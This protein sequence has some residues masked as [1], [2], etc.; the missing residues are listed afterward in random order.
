MLTP[1]DDYPIHPS[2]DPIAHPATGDPNHYD[3]Y[4]FNGHQK[5]G[6]FYF[7]AAMGHYPVRGV[8]DAAFSIVLDG[9]EH[10]VFASGVMPVDRTTAVGPIRIEVSRAHPHHPLRGRAERTRDRV[11]PR[12]PGPDGRRRGAPAK[13]DL[14][15]GHPRDGPHPADPVGQLGGRGPR[16]RHRDQG[17][18]A[19]GPRERATGRGERGPWARRSR[20]IGRAACRTH[21]G[22]GRRCT[23]TT[24]APTSPCT[25]TPTA[26]AGSRP[27]SSWNRC[28]T[29]PFPGA[30]RASWSAAPSGTSS[31][32][33]PVVARSDGRRCRS[34]TPTR[35]RCTSS[36]R[37]SSPSAC[38]G[39]GYT[40]PYWG[41]GTNHGELET[42]RESIPLGDFEPLDWSSIHVQNVV[43]AR[44][45]DRTGIGVLEELH[46]GPHDPP[47]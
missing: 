23:S 15:S 13:K 22:Y 35:V 40:H 1:F 27:P 33:N 45:G 43:R 9:V 26:R 38:A 41:H 32:S 36:W 7:G 5:D 20:P 29:T 24:A 11:R 16:R 10:S 39:I 30:L 34:C 6:D 17:R 28:P 2:A 12:L 44:M 4:W 47:A 19:R 46:F 3:R 14:R 25:R 18:P 31:L 8:V 42:G 37:S 21:S